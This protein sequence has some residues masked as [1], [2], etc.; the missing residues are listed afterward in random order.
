MHSISL[1]VDNYI[2]DGSLS[3]R[4]REEVFVGGNESELE[5]KL[6]PAFCNVRN[7]KIA[8]DG[9]KTNNEQRASNPL[10]E[11]FPAPFR[12]EPQPRGI[13]NPPLNFFPPPFLAPVPPIGPRIGGAD[14]GMFSCF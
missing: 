8:E 7:K 4:S 14:L 12:N 9:S 2:T 1:K 10:L 6:K 3:D 13:H 11:N 5:L